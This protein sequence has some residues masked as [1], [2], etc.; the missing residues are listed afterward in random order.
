MENKTT[1]KSRNNWRTG[2]KKIEN[3]NQIQ[4]SWTES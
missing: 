1:V 3:E 2:E 4:S